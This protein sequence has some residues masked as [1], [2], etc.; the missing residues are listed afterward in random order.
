METRHSQIQGAKQ[1]LCGVNTEKATSRH[2]INK[3]LKTSNKKEIL[4][5][6]R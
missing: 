4:E 5:A 1:T 6:A 3:L 2:I